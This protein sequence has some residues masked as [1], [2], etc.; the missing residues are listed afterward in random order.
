MDKGLSKEFG[1]IAID[2][3]DR[4]TGFQ[5]KPDSPRTLH[6]K[7]DKILASMGIYVFNT[8]IMVRKLIDD[9]K[10]RTS[11]DF[12]RDIIPAMV[13]ASRV[14]AY[15]FVNGN[16]GV[17]RVKHGFDFCVPALEPL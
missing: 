4:I 12:G 3:D 5:E 13:D 10:K 11:H 14:F 16:R 7:P 6:N 17:L 15:N 1:V 8:E 2:S 9:A